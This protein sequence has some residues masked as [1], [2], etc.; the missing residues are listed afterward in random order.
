VALTA[1]DA[2]PHVYQAA[3]VAVVPAPHSSAVHWLLAVPVL[4][5]YPVPHWKAVA[6]KSML[7][8]WQVPAVEPDAVATQTVF[9]ASPDVVYLQGEDA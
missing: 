8:T 3:H 6:V 2:S 5:V 7:Q 9:K 4:Q 1:V